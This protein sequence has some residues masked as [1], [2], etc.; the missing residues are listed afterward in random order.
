MQHNKY[1]ELKGS[2]IAGN[3]FKLIAGTDNKYSCLACLND[4]FFSRTRLIMTRLRQIYVFTSFRT[5]AV[6]EGK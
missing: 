1:A 6:L 4:R 3:Y 5:L 2:E